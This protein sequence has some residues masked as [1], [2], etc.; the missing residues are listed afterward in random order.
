MKLLTLAAVLVLLFLT[1]C[2][3][4]HV[5]MPYSIELNK[6]ELGHKRGEASMY[7]LLWLVAWGDAGAASAAKAGDITVL[8]HMDREIESVLFGI[9]SRNTTI[10]YG[11]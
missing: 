8:T 7:S 5:T 11:D 10:V 3:Y 1:G 2:V 4:T 6:T 9:Y